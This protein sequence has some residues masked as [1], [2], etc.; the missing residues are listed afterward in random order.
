MISKNELRKLYKEKRREIPDKRQKSIKIAEKLFSTELYKNSKT[1][2]LFYPLSN[3]VN[4]LFIFEKAVKDGKNV[5]FPVT[6]E[7]TNEI[8]PVYYKNGFVKGA[9]NI[10]EPLR[11]EKVEK[12]KKSQKDEIDIALLPALASDRE[13][14]RLGYGGGCYDRFLADFKGKKITLLF[15]ELLCH[16]LPRDKF[17]IKADLV[18]T[19]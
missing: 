17:D 18:I 4:T 7:K 3:E 12:V 16:R 9:Y 14:Y 2:M 10:F 19:D 11:F 13:N 8:T 1:I 15:K 6:D 5:V